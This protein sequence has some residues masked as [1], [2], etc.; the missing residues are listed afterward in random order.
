MILNGSMKLGARIVAG[1][2]AVQFAV[3]DLEAPKKYQYVVRAADFEVR[4]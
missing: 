3:H 1:E 4:P 2:Y